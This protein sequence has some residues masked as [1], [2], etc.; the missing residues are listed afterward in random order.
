MS[1]SAPTT[2]TPVIEAELARSGDRPGYASS[3]SRESNLWS[4]AKKASPAYLILAAFVVIGVAVRVVAFTAWWPASTTLADAIPY[5]AYAES[6]PLGDPQHPV[7][8]PAMLALLGFVTRDL[9]VTIVV[10]HLLGL[11]S[12]LV[13]FAAVRRLTHSPWPA[14][15]PAGVV[16]LN[17]DLVFLEHTIMSE[18]PF[19]AAMAVAIYASVRAIDSPD[20]WWRWPAASGALIGLAGL[21]RSTAL[22]LLPIAALAIL[23]ARGRPWRLSWRAP[24]A[25]A[26]VGAILLGGYAFANLAAN[27]RFE[28]GP[29][30]GWHL[31]ARVAPFA[32]CTQFDPP[33]GT[34]RL[35]ETTPPDSRPGGDFYLYQADS[36]ALKA[37]GPQPWREHDG[38]MGA[39]AR[40]AIWHQPKTYALTIWRD[41][42][43]FFVP[44]AR[45]PRTFAGG[46]LDAE[47]DWTVWYPGSAKT[48]RDVR[49]GMQAFF[50]PFRTSKSDGSLAFLHDYQRVFRFGAT[51]LTITTLL[52]LLGLFVGPRRSRV[53]VLLFGVGGLVMLAGPTLS[54]YAIGR[55][56]VPVAPMIAAGAAIVVWTLWRMEAERRRRE[57]AIAAS[58]TTS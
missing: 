4:R 40:Q 38:D 44:S 22:F 12:G 16:L 51:M 41:V 33:A 21:M 3:A 6:D 31:Y 54:V 52:I 18:G 1:K 42:R 57:G 7:G 55:Y 27:G 10:Q 49:A 15:A 47:L 26:G 14:L 29:A 24:V 39:F 35:C 8:Y 43:Y 9:A 17:A 13:L 34:R 53:G 11:A 2:S 28:V 30:Q 36:P 23:L 20:P 46:D 19:V 5:S 48:V 50:D 56:T 32:D 37:Y 25:T 58:G 45:K